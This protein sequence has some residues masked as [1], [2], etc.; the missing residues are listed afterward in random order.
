VSP[1]TGHVESDIRTVSDVWFDRDSHNSVEEFV[2]ALPLAYFGFC[3]DDRC[4]YHGQRGSRP[5][6]DPYRCPA[7]GAQWS[8]RG[9][10][11]R[12]TAPPRKP[13][14]R[15]G[16]RGEFCRRT[17]P[18]ADAA[19]PDAPRLEPI[20]ND[21]RTLCWRPRESDALGTVHRSFRVTTSGL[22][23]KAR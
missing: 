1:C 11:D 18:R 12:G 4:N 21:T 22:S 13:E 14:C 9:C 17:A 2:R 8:V 3:V 16:Y 6:T 15:A 20:G 23:L 7:D 10:T 5:T 19:S